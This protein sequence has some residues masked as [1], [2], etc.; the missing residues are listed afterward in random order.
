MSS[1]SLL[2]SFLIASAGLR[3]AA[4]IAA[5]Q[6]RSFAIWGFAA[7]D[8]RGLAPPNCV[9]AKPPTGPVT[10]AMK[11]QAASRELLAAFSTNPRVCTRVNA[12]LGPAGCGT[13]AN[14]PQNFGVLLQSA[15]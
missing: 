5:V 2:R 10:Q 15:S 13:R 8:A 6:G 7:T 14:L 4:C 11:L 12:P 1:S 3:A 9:Y